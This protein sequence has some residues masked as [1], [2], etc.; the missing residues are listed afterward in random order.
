M[1]TWMDLVENVGDDAAYIWSDF[2]MGAAD[3]MAQ[4]QALNMEMLG[5]AHAYLGQNI[6]IDGVPLNQVCPSYADD[7]VSL[8]PVDL[9]STKN[10]AN[11]VA[12]AAPQPHVA[13]KVTIDVQDIREW[14][15]YN[16]AKW[17]GLNAE[18]DA[19]FW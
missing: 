14:A 8:K 13:T 16:A 17:E 6:T 7:W 19:A 2:E 5:R 12:K 18:R 9:F 3:L 4:E 11:T 15:I 10:I 1:Y